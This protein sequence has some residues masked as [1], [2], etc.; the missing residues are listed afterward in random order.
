MIIGMSLFG[1]SL[2]EALVLRSDGGG[3]RVAPARGLTSAAR[4]ARKLGV[5][6]CRLPVDASLWELRAM[7]GDVAGIAH[8][9]RKSLGSGN[10]REM[11]RRHCTGI[12]TGYYLNADRGCFE[13]T[14]VPVRSQ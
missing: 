1:N 6:I 3:A 11:K 5:K 10:W 9:P 7:A 4:R 13:R 2:F 12:P 14:R 8:A